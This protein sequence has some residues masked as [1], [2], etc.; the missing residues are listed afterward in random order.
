LAEYVKR[1]LGAALARPLQEH[2]REAVNELYERLTKD[3][4]EE[5]ETPVQWMITHGDVW[6]HN[7]LVHNN[8]IGFTDI[9][10]PFEPALADVAMVQRKWLLN[11][12]AGRGR[13]LEEDEVVK[14]IQGYTSVRPFRQ[15]DLRT[16]SI[17]WAAFH[18][19]RLT[20]QAEDLEKRVNDPRRE[21]WDV[22]G[23]ILRLPDSI[24]RVESLLSRL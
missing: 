8:T 6:G 9:N 1:R 14:F 17:I 20:F 21:H 15:E 24:Q 22:F 23:E 5:M 19:D 4:S 16:F 10:A 18:A 7:V 2:Q 11:D 13:P 3:Y 12:R